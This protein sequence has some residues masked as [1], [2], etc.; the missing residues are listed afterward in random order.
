MK[1]KPGNDLYVRRNQPF[2][3]D[4]D[5]AEAKGKPEEVQESSTDPRRQP[6]QSLHKETAV[7]SITEEIADTGSAGGR[8]SSAAS[9]LTSSHVSE[10]TGKSSISRRNSVDVLMNSDFNP[11]ADDFQADFS[12]P[13]TQE[14]DLDSDD[15]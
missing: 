10:R 5:K 7:A 4:E 6:L 2:V 15:F 13:L 8:K 12:N 11:L 3:F 9:T 14:D 1:P